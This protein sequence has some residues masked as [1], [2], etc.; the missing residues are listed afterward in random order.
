MRLPPL[1]AL[2]PA[3][4]LALA[5]VTAP[6]AEAAAEEA[7]KLANARCLDGRA[8][9]P[10]LEPVVIRWGGKT[11]SVN[12][13]SRENADALRKMAPVEALRAVVAT[14]RDLAGQV[15][16]PEREKARER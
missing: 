2:A 6:A 7:V 10:R 11:W 16:L 13:A 5:A 4:V 14:N 1:R 8:V 15:P 9:D 12:V 3:L